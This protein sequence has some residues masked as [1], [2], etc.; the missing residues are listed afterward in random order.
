LA[1]ELGMKPFIIGENCIIQIKKRVNI[2]QIALSASAIQ[3]LLSTIASVSGTIESVIS[4]KA[5][6][7]DTITGVAHAIQSAPDTIAGGGN[8]IRCEHDAMACGGNETRPEPDAMT[9][10]G[11]EIKCVGYEIEFVGNEIGYVC[12]TFLLF[13]LLC[14][15]YSGL[16][17]FVFANFRMLHMR[18]L[19]FNSFGIIEGRYIVCM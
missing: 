5:R 13:V 7:P 9:D 10:G 8:E 14:S 18:L 1:V 15:S 3:S 17:S 2:G 19:L 4:A 12:I 16:F 11:N 6:E